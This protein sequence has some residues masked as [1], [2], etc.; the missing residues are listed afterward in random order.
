VTATSFTVG[1]RIQAGDVVVRVVGVSPDG[2]PTF[3]RVARGTLR[4]DLG[5]RQQAVLRELHEYGAATRAQLAEHVGASSTAAW[6]AIRSLMTRGLVVESGGVTG[7]R[8]RRQPV[9]ALAD[10]VEVEVDADGR[11]M[12]RIV[13][14]RRRRAT[15]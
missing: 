15:R 9:Y 2:T 1:Q 14:V 5:T 12:A 8:G 6:Q 13:P 10:G 3:R 7:H 11:I 4:G